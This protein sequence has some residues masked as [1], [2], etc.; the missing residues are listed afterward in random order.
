MLNYYKFIYFDVGGVAIKDFSP[1][2]KYIELKR[3]VELNKNKARVSTLYSLNM[4]A[5]FVSAW[6]LTLVLMVKRM[7][8]L[9][10]PDND[11]YSFLRD[12]LQTVLWFPSGPE[13]G[14]FFILADS[15]AGRRSSQ[16]TAYS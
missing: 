2:N 9:Q 13:G 5:K 15:G 10:I 12:F 14:R 11:N 8:S 1:T 6:I 3:D 4:K 16:Q 7:P